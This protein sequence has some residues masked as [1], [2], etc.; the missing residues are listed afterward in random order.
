MSYG[1]TPD[2]RQPDPGE[3]PG[4]FQ[5]TPQ[6]SPMYGE[7]QFGGAPWPQ[8]PPGYPQPGYG[9]PGYGQPGYGQP[10]YG[11]GVTFHPVMGRGQAGKSRRRTRPGSGSPLLAGSCS[12]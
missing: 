3:Q 10:G 4:S 7:G 11:P 8:P 9:Q 12:A 5:P 6:P 2:D 1:S